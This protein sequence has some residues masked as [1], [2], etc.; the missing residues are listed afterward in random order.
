MG[1]CKKVG[2][3]TTNVKVALRHPKSDKKPSG[4]AKSK[5]SAV[6]AEAFGVA[7]YLLDLK[8]IGQVDMGYGHLF[9]AE[10][11]TAAGAGKVYVRSVGVV[12]LGVVQVA[13]AEA[14]ASGAA[15]IIYFVQQVVFYQQGEGAEDGR[16][17]DAHEHL[18][19]LGKREGAFVG[20]YGSQDKQAVGRGAQACCEEHLFG[21]V[22]IHTYYL[23]CGTLSRS[24]TSWSISLSVVA[25]LVTKRTSL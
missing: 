22:V 25:Q 13:L 2:R 6:G 24:A 15:A 20:E 12:V 14:V 9:D 17:I 7:A 3:T 10:C 5:L 8:G 18:F 21:I 4:E 23:F 16:L 1:G 11:A 19:H